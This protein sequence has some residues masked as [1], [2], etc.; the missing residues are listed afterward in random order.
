MMDD[1]FINRCIIQR[2]RVVVD[3]SESVG[4][5]IEEAVSAFYQALAGLGFSDKQIFDAFAGYSN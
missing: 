2:E 3:V 5:R 4:C 1:P